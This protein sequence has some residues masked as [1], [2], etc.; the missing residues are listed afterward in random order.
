MKATL[1]VFTLLLLS[2]CVARE[3]STINA[4]NAVK[5]FCKK[6]SGELTVSFEGGAFGNSAKVSCTARPAP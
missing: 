3:E 4:M 2:G 1:I 6:S 5:D